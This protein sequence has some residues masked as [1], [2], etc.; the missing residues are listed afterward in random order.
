MTKSYWLE[1]FLLMFSQMEMRI[2]HQNKGIVLKK[3]YKN[4]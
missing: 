2:K 4:N 1:L 3:L